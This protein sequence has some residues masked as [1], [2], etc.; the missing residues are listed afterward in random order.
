[1][2]GKET[3]RRS[4][5]R[6]R[7][8]RRIDKNFSTRALKASALESIRE[9][10]GKLAC[11][12]GEFSRKLLVSEKAFKAMILEILPGNSEICQRGAQNFCFTRC[13]NERRR[14]IKLFPSDNILED[15]SGYWIFYKFFGWWQKMWKN[16]SFVRNSYTTDE[17][18][19][20]DSHSPS[21]KDFRRHLL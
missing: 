11:S 4:T 13:V 3:R 8:N 5:L 14:E 6:S 9:T 20:T 18:T 1:M 19:S 7:R 16:H 21:I 2:R 17:T 15:Q 10:F 12:D